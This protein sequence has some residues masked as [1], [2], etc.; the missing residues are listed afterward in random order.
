[1]KKVFLFFV[2]VL[3]FLSSCKKDDNVSDIIYVSDVSSTAPVLLEG[4]SGGVDVDYVVSSEPVISKVEEKKGTTFKKVS[5]KDEFSRRYNTNG[6]PQAGLFIRSD[7]LKE[8]VDPLLYYVD[9]LLEDVSNGG[10]KLKEYIKE[11]Y[12]EKEFSSIFGISER[13]LEKDNLLS[14]LGFTS[15]ENSL[16]LEQL[17]KCSKMLD[18]SFDKNLISPF[19]ND[20]SKQGLVTLSGIVPSGAPGILFSEYP[21]SLVEISTPD[22]IKAEFSKAEKDFIV[23]DSISGMKLS[24]MN[25]NSYLLVKILTNGN[26]FLVDLGDNNPLENSTIVSFGEGLIPDSVFKALYSQLPNP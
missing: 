19:Y 26:L 16:T 21:K 11:N 1:M 18:F 23:F 14:S 20:R 2:L 15:L 3:V 24:K 7:I 17:E 25:N 22:V 10:D 5:L 6:F 12:S 9:S 13:L 8:D 4:K